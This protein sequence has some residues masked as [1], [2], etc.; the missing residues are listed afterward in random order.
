MLGLL[1]VIPGA[2]ADSSK[3]A[4]TLLIARSPSG[5]LNKFSHAISRKIPNES[6]SRSSNGRFAHYRKGGFQRS[7]LIIN[8]KDFKKMKAAIAKNQELKKFLKKLIG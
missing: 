1:L 8:T 4:D 7:P 2:A 6:N 3:S 5:F